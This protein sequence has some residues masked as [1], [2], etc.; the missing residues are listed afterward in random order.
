LVLKSYTRFLLRS[1]NSGL[2]QNEAYKYELKQASILFHPVKN[3][4]K[5]INRHIRIHPKVP[6]FTKQFAYVA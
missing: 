2:A 1:I 5:A 3:F 6:E 4:F